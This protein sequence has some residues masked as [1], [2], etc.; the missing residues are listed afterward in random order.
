MEKVKQLINQNEKG[1]LTHGKIDNGQTTQKVL[2]KTWSWKSRMLEE[3]GIEVIPIF[4]FGLQGGR[5]VWRAAQIEE[6]M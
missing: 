4:P 6:T 5:P 3:M 2:E 1:Y